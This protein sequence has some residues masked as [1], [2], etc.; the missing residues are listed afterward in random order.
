MVI[1]LYFSFPENQHGMM[2]DKVES[3][4]EV[5]SAGWTW[6]LTDRFEPRKKG[7]AQICCSIGH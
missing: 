2:D 3:E 7:G 4:D 5:I 1:I 6:S